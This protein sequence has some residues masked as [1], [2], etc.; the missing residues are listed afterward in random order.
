[1]TTAR[2]YFT[3]QCQTQQNS[4]LENSRRQRRRRQTDA[5]IDA[6][7]N[8][9]DSVRRDYAQTRTERDSHLKFFFHTGRGTSPFVSLVAMLA[10]HVMRFFSIVLVLCPTAEL[11]RVY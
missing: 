3:D 11:P 7:L 10:A 6:C 9:K 5:V 2:A 8:C 4:L 1:M